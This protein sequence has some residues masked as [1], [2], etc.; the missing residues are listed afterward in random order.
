MAK[1]L[2][3]HGKRVFKLV[4]DAV[5]LVLLALMF[6]KQAISLAFHEIGGLALVG[7]FVVHHLL[8]GKWIAAVTKRLF[9]KGTG[10]LERASYIVDALLL[11]SFLTVGVTG[12]LISEVVFRF[13]VAGS[14]KTLHYF[15]SA[16]SVV[17]MGV[18][19]GLH[20]DYIFGRLLKKGGKK[21]AKAVLAVVL[22]AAVAFGG[23]SLFSSDFLTFLT[24]PVRTANFAH[25]QFTPSGEP[26]LDGSDRQQPMDLSELPDAGTEQNSA[27]PAA[28]GDGQTVPDDGP[29]LGGGQRQGRH[30]GSGGGLG[31]GEGR[32]GGTGSVSAA[33][34]LAAQ[35]IGIM[36]LFAALTYPVVRLLHKRGKGKNAQADGE[37]AA[38]I[39]AESPAAIPAETTAPDENGEPEE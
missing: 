5:M 36:T 35:Y 12:V 27:G 19:L 4:L 38:E 26:A 8:N 37:P 16:L 39:P 28:P 11:V 13:N 29:G 1:K 15:V 22:T 2:D 31:G 10:R 17:L 20:A 25:G 3:A 32:G 23:Y 30:N 7:L 21:A 34:L 14:V 18:H 9:A 33:L 6:R 24:A